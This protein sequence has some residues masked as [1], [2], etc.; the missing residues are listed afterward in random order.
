MA[1]GLA[2]RAAGAPR[3]GRTGRGAAEEVE[4]RWSHLADGVK[5]KRDGLD[6]DGLRKKH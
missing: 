4:G 5:M 1:N 3:Q 2:E 6:D